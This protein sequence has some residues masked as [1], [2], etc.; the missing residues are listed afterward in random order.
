M[1]RLII[2][3]GIAAAVVIIFALVLTSQ[4][5]NPAFQTA[6]DL[7]IAL[8]K[9]D[10]QTALS[11][12]DESMRAYVTDRCPNGSP[13]ACIVTPPEWGALISAVFRRAAPDGANW[14]VEVIANYEQDRGAS[15]VCSYIRVEPDAA[16][17]WHVAGWAGFIHCG[18]PA[19]RDMPTNPDTPNR[20][21]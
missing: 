14:D 10:D 19:S 16:G 1:N 18:D 12:L 13:S 3:L 20:A 11:L 7:V 17:N 9:G 6:V 15:G 21:P 8:G 5:I 2:G 4:G